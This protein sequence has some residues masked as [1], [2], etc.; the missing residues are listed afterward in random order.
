MIIKIIWILKTLILVPFFGGYKFPSYI[1]NPIYLRNL[2]SIY[3]GSRVR[4]LPHSRIEGITKHAKIIFEGDISIGQN[5]HCTASGEL[6]IS[7]HTTIL[8]NVCI[9]DTD[10]DYQSINQHVLQQP[11][12]IRKTEIGEYC[13]IGFG[14]V[15]QAGTILGNQCIVGANSVVRGTFKDHSVI[16]G[17]PARV[18]KRFNKSTG[19][20][21]KTDNQGNFI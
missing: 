13:F 11:C 21:E 15:I 17:S 6:K 14:A 9:T 2:K 1:V 12:T 10:H 5:L 19:N 3:V 4:I 16:V 8:G 7:K 18:V 20:W